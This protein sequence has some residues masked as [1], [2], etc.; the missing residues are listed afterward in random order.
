ME[1]KYFI[2]VHYP[3]TNKKAENVEYACRFPIFM[4]DTQRYKWST[5]ELDKKRCYFMDLGN[6]MQYIRKRFEKVF[7]QSYIYTIYRQTEDDI[8]VVDSFDYKRVVSI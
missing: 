8:Q 2:R 7:N 6:C 1:E 5:S 4:K 3:K